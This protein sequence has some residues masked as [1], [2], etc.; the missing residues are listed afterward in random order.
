LDD[1]NARSLGHLVLESVEG[2][3]SLND[4]FVA[5]CLFLSVAEHMEE[6]LVSNKE[7]SDK[8]EEDVREK[9]WRSSL[10]NAMTEELSR[11]GEE[12]ENG[13]EGEGLAE[14]HAV[15][16]V[17][18]VVDPLGA[19]HGC[20][21]HRCC[22]KADQNIAINVDHRSHHPDE[23]PDVEDIDL[24]FS[25]ISL[26]GSELPGWFVFSEVELEDVGRWEVGE[27]AKE[28]TEDDR[29]E[30]A[31]NNHI[32]AIGVE[33]SVLPVQIA[34]RK[35]CTA[36]LL[37]VFSWNDLEFLFLYHFIFSEILSIRYINNKD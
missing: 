2:Y 16:V 30:D 27:E 9:S 28:A 14:E 10:K 34:K 3:V 20:H 19:E 8:H 25:W 22:E 7:W 31:V 24:L 15:W 17:V 23:C 35:R 29:Y 21:A 18:Q 32:S 5:V 37:L 6:G 4:I 1:F 36:W 12:L 33:S 13:E 11:P 26:E